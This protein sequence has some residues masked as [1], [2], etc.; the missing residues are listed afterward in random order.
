MKHETSAGAIVYYRD[1]ETKKILFLILHYTAG[2]WDLPKGKLEQGETKLDAAIREVKEETGLE[3]TPDTNFEQSFSYYFKDRQGNLVQ[4]DV[5]FFIA[6]STTKD[7][8]LSKEHIYYK[9]L[10][11]G[12]AVRQI[13]F[14]NARQLLYMADHY[15]QTE[16]APERS[17]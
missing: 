6:E 4:K 10:P 17:N 5:T 2:H 14:Q 9:W 11:F 16:S 3:V 8:T 12:D 13:T 7:V 1:P 15:I